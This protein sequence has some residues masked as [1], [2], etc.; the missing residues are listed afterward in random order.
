MSSRRHRGSSMRVDIL[1]LSS[2]LRQERLYVQH[3]KAQLQEL[4]DKVKLSS[5][6]L[7]HTA[8][9][10][11]QQRNNLDGLIFSSRGQDVSPAICCQRANLLEQT[12]FQDS[13]KHLS[14][15]EVQFLTPK[16]KKTHCNW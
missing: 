6:R 15:H 1:D 12:I 14:H 9:V 7:A 10:A 4:N 8:W 2:R 3:E 16:G 5:K 13:Y 11:Y